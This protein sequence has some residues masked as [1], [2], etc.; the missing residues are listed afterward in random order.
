M[1]LIPS[2]KKIK[3]LDCFLLLSFVMYT[4]SN[5]TTE[6]KNMTLIIRHCFFIHGVLLL[7]YGKK[8]YII[9]ISTSKGKYIALKYAA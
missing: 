3:I 8:Q 2:W 9:S 7:W 1:E 4:M 5:Y 6:L